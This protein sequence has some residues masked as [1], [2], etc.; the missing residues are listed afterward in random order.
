MTHQHK[1]YK[2]VSIIVLNYNSQNFIEN[3]LKSILQID[4]PDYE[5]IFVDNA[6]TDKSVEIAKSILKSSFAH[7]YKIIVNKNNIG[8]EGR[9]IGARYSTGEYLVFLDSDVRVDPQWLK[10]VLKV[11]DDDPKVGVVMPKLLSAKDPEILDNAGHYIDVFGITYFIGRLQ[12]E[13]KY[14]TR[15]VIFGAAGPALVIKSDLFH[16][17]GGFDSDYF[18]LFEES[19][20]CWRVW[21]SGYKVIF[22]PKS[23]VY[24]WGA[25]SY[26]GGKGYN[27]TF[28]F[29]RNRL[30][31]MIKNYEI[32]NMLK[33]VTGN[34]ILMLTLSLLHVIHKDLIRAKATWDG[35]FYNFKVLKHTL[36]KRIQVQRLRKVTDS[37]LINNEVIKKF[38]IK[39]LIKKYKNLNL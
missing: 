11:F 31:S 24:H 21:I 29:V 26:K 20:L 30:A 16:L 1:K 8:T 39:K 17:L 15:N 13:V 18:L 3:C 37:Q 38:N 5:I 27:E 19:D 25:S 7:S 22:E 14:T 34:I 23:R 10:E 4:Y 6:S 12:K 28:L 32:I 33:Y 35:I 36:S 2:R 9:N